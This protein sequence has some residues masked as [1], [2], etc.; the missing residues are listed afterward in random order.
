[1]SEYIQQAIRRP[2]SSKGQICVPVE[3]R[4]GVEAYVVKEE[5]TE[6][7]EAPVLTLIPIEDSTE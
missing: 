1:M 6:N 3:F 7:D 5:P 2:V 4:D